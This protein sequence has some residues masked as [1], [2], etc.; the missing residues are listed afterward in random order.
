MKLL[1]DIGNSRVK[2]ACI[3][4]EGL[5]DGAYFERSKSG[6]KA[7]LNKHWKNLTDIESI[8]VSNV[9]G[10]K[11]AKQL[12]EW[13]Q[14][15]W[16]LEP[17]F[18]VSES[19]RFGVTNAY[20]QPEKLGV[21]RWLGLIAARQ[22]ARVATCTIDCGTAITVDVITRNGEH[23]GGLILA[24]LG[25]IRSSLISNTD[26]LTESVDETEIKTLATN[27]YSAIQVGSLYSITATLEQLIADLKEQ[28][29]NRIRFIIT[30][31]D[32]EQLLKMLPENVAHY[33]DLVLKGLAYYAR[34][35]DRHSQQQNKKNGKTK[36]ND[37]SN[38]KTSVQRY[39]D[40]HCSSK[41]KE[42]SSQ[43]KSETEQQ[44]SAEP[45]NKVEQNET[46][47]I[48]QETEA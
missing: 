10:E 2:W 7:A 47:E 13:A 30:G 48:L 34:Q 23:Q 19:K 46:T 16:Q 35:K 14:K 31:G 18:I 6:I 41:N 5:T 4:E 38:T 24:G 27:T 22:H 32:A 33:P 44:D 17:N 9:A 3:T 26:A 45:V 39:I 1:V 25:L 21:D 37:R 8:Y 36:K 15:K 40:K 43:K 11:I 20:E 28:F 42:T 12:T 29:D